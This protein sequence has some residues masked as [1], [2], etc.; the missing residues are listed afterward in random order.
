M[1]LFTR[2]ICSHNPDEYKYILI[3]DAFEQY[4][5]WINHLMDESYYIWA[6]RWVKERFFDSYKS[7]DE[8]LETEI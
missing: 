3:N 6:K 4:N 8:W 7:F 2:K 5:E 1:K